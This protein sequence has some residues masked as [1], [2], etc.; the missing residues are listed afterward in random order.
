MK[1]PIKLIA[2]VNLTAGAGEPRKFNIVAYN[3]GILPIDGFEHPVVADL[4]GMVEADSVSIVLDHTTTVDTTVGSTDSILNDGH[5]LT[6]KGVVTGD[7]RPQVKAALMQHD[8]GHRWQASIGALVTQEQK[9]AAG[10]RVVVNGRSFEGPIIVARQWELRHVGILPSGADPTTSV[11]LA[12][13]AAIHGETKMNFEQWVQDTFATDVAQLSPE[14]VALLQE[15]YDALQNAGSAGPAPAATAQAGA[16]V[17]LRAQAAAEANRIAA[18]QSVAA[19]HPQ[20]MAA[21]IANGWNAE[22]TEIAVL[23]AQRPQSPNNFHRSGN[24]LGELD[25]GKVLVASLAINHGCRPDVLAKSSEIGERTVDAAT[26]LQH[27]GATIHT[28]LRACMAAAGVTPP[29]HSVGDSFIRAGFEAS[30]MLHASGLSTMSLPGILSST[31]D[32]ILL[33][34]F[35][36]VPATWQNFCAVTSAPNFKPQKRYRLVTGNR[37][38]ELA[39]GGHLKDMGFKPE[40]EYESQLKT[41]GCVLTLDRQAIINDDLGAFSKLLGEMGR[42]GMMKLERTVYEVLF[43]AISGGAFF[44]AGRGNLITGTTSAL[45]GTTGINAL[46]LAV[47]AFDGMVDANSEPMM[48]VPEIIL[49]G[50]TLANSARLLTRDTQVVAVGVGA[51]AA[52]VPDGNPHAGQYRPVKSPW[53]ENDLITGN[54]TTGW[55]LFAP[56]QGEAG[57]IEVS[58]LNGQQTPTTEQGEL[59]F[60]QLGLAL[61]AYFDFGAAASDYRFGVW[62]TGVAP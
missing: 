11:N 49:T 32:K 62:N 18:V 21:A 28:V 5:S 42:H 48:L 12:A 8:K 14:L 60:T 34:G 55:G 52:T 3:G 41:R 27:R 22:R 44:T 31:A 6:L 2:A 25:P 24:G 15:K 57:L 40:E 30:R 58:F 54:T 43:A 35:Q 13:A 53:I 39:P 7:H 9:I 10:Q 20:I 38:E 4:Q 46:S 29:S 19:A 36:S 26:S 56:P 45:N 23:K 16:T 47:A 37:F 61:R 51:S 17:N 33:N 59:D 50:P 1:K